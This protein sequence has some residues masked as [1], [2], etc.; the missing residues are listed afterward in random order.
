V[1]VE[2]FE[3]AV[4]AGDFDCFGGLI[5]EDPIRSYEPDF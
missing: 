4:L 2:H 5:D 3:V 1:A